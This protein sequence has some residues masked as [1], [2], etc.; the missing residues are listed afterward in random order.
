LCLALL[1]ACTRST[2]PIV[3]VTAIPTEGQS[4]VEA[5]QPTYIPFEITDTFGVVWVP[6]DGQLDVHNP[7]GVAGSIV[8]R[9][10]Y[11]A[12]GIRLTGNTTSL[13]SSLWVEIQTAADQAGWV[14]FWNLTEDVTA[15]AFC[16]DERSYDLMRRAAEAILQQD[17]DALAGMIN[18]ERGLMIRQEWWNPEVNLNAEQI[19]SI[20]ED[21]T[22]YD[23]GEQSGGEFRTTGTFPGVILPLLKD[24][25]EDVQQ[26]TCGH[27]Q[28]GVS[29]TP[30]EWP[31]E[32]RNLHYFGF[33]RPAPE[34][35]NPYDWRAWGFGFEYIR[36]MP[37]LTVAVHFHGDV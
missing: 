36:G 23:W 24:V 21:R 18:P 32:Y 6:Q 37:Y 2:V 28:Y 4:T 15:D 14:N 33:S 8:E 30:A 27:I 5:S 20:F 3:Q 12:T 13:G 1:S 16:A 7:A 34:K 22:S 11:D 35:G 29:S 10:D 17:G 25:L 19:G 31:S 26:P 9:F